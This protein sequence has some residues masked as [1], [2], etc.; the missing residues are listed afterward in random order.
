MTNNKLTPFQSGFIKCDSTTNQITSFYNDI[1]KAIDDG[2]EVRAVFCDIAKAFDRVWHPGLLFKLSSF[3]IRGSLQWFSSYLSGRQQRVVYSSSCSQWAPINA[4]VPQGSI[5]GP[6]NFLIFINDIV[7]CIHSNIRLFADD[8]S[9]YIIVEDPV[10]SS[11]TLNADLSTI[12]QWSE[13]WLV[14]FNSSKTKTMTFSRKQNRVQHPDLTM[15]GAVIDKVKEHKHLGFTFS[16]DAKWNIHISTCLDSAWQ[17]IGILR[18]LKF[19]LSRSSLERMYFSFIRS[20]LEYGDVVWDNC[21]IQ[22]KNDIEAV[23]TEAAR[24]VSGATKLCNIARLYQYLTCESLSDRRKKH[25]L[26]QFYKRKVT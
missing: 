4:G 23:Q 5:R 26:F 2:K 18:S 22:L 3:G 9:I 15:N 8:T 19:R 24:I 21:S 20:L 6:L 11:L 14:R 16:D 10:T 17:R 13:A 7:Q 1:C 25:R 12:H